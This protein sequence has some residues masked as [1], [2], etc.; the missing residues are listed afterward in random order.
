MSRS[1]LRSHLRC[2]RIH[3]LFLVILHLV[4]G[5]SPPHESQYLSFDSRRRPQFGQTLRWNKLPKMLEGFSFSGAGWAALNQLC[6]Q[7]WEFTAR[8]FP[9][10]F[11]A[12]VD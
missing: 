2:S 5:T 6:V 4:V 7:D 1:T 8:C 3:V 9:L 11:G 12:L 10:W